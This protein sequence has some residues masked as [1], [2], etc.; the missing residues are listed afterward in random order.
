MRGQ[1]NDHKSMLI[2]VSKYIRVNRQIKIQ[3]INTVE[4]IKS[5]LL[6]PGTEEFSTLRNEIEKELNNFQKKNEF[7]FEEMFNSE[8]GLK[9]VVSE[10]SLNIKNLSGDSVDYLDYEQYKRSKIGLADNYYRWRQAITRNN[11]RRLKHKLL[12]KINKNV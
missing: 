9:Y 2:H 4:K 10:I 3:V 8:I 7:N 11:P 12:F 6:N 5:I 1:I